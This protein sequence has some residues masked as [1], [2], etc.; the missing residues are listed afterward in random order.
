MPWGRNPMHSVKIVNADGSIGEMRRYDATGRDLHIDQPLSQI[1]VNY[2]P[3]AMIADLIAPVV[4]VGKQ[5]DLFFQFNQADLWRI[6]DT[7]RS[8]MRAAKRVDL[9]VSSQ[10][11][12]CKNYAL[13]T[14]ISIEDAV[15]ADAMLDLRVNKGKFLV[16]LLMLDY[17]N[18][19]AS[20]VINT[21]NVGSMCVPTSVAGGSQGP[22]NDRINADPVLDIDNAIERMR[23][24][25]GYKPNK[26]VF[27]WKA[28]ADFRRNAKVRALLFPSAGGVTPGAGLVRPEQL[29]DVFGLD[30]VLIGGAMQ[31]TAAE[32]L[33]Q[34]LSDMW[35]P[36]VLLY[37]AP[38]RPSKEVP[39]FMYSFRW[40]AAGLPSAM[41]AEDLGYNRELK[42]N[43]IEV[44]LYQDEKVV[45][46]NLAT[47]IAS[48][49]AS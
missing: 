34:S 4:T 48:A 42:G 12:Y 25:S 36:H 35:G 24:F 17:E 8:P 5:S 9:N 23:T 21:S 7:S 46:S 26:A 41:V 27:G 29:A 6:P 44:D 2:R 14:G 49:T 22:W 33:S 18:R 30:Q 1:L 15:N 10:T 13:A 19:V 40:Q 45:A 11:Y 47:V 16:D 43:L 3:P 20:T 39:S 28:W 38:E 32:G 31:N 37:Y